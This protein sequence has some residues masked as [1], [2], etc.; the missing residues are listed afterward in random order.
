MLFRSWG[1]PR[2]IKVFYGSS[3]AGTYRLASYPG[4]WQDVANGGWTQLVTGGFTSGGVSANANATTKTIVSGN[5]ESYLQSGKTN[6]FRISSPDGY[7]GQAPNEY[8]ARTGTAIAILSIK[9]YTRN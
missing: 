3:G 9:G 1:Y 6:Q 7:S 5:L 4:G 2:A 8:L